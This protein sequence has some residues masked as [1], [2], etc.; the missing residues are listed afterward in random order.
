MVH[1]FDFVRPF[2]LHKS[3][4]RTYEVTVATRDLLKSDVMPSDIQTPA[5]Q[6]NLL[7]PSHSEHIGSRILRHAARLACRYRRFG[8]TVFLHHTLNMYE[9]DLSATPPHTYQTIRY[10]IPKTGVS[11]FTAVSNSV[12]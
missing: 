9:A 4:W 2:F 7:P 1:I 8:E 10:H 5:F 12:L 6:R 11:T 3:F